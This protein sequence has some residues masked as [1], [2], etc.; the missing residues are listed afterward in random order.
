M[1]SEDDKSLH[2]KIGYMRAEIK[3]VTAKVDTVIEKVD[4][5][6]HKLVVLNGST[7][8]QEQC[9]ARM[10]RSDDSQPS[11]VFSDVTK[12]EPKKSWLLRVKENIAAILVICGFASLLGAGFYKVAHLMVGIETILANANKESKKQTNVI[13]K[14]ISKANVQPKV[15]YLPVYPDAGTKKYQPRRRRHR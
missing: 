2:E 8:K 12:E 6:D 9:E 5:V 13:K 7:V 4:C 15:I 10:N 11:I 1:S 14:E 3:G